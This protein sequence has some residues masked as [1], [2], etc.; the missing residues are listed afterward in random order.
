MDISKK[1]PFFPVNKQLSKYLLD[2]GRVA[3]LP[4]LYE[5]LLRYTDGFPLLDKQGEDTLWESVLYAEDVIR[6]FND[7]LTFV[8]SLL[9]TDG[10]MSFMKHLYVDR[11]DYCHFGNSKPF[12]IR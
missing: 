2:V 9:K 12:R 6:E 10:D 5:D 8:Y 3:K 11:I 4:I 7:G 1:K